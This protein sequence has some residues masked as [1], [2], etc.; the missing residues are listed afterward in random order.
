MEVLAADDEST[1]HLGGHNGASED[2]TADRDKS[3]EGTFLVCKLELSSASVFHY[4]TS[5]HFFHQLFLELFLAS[6]SIAPRH[7][8]PM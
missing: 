2:T 8:I 3:S 7:H 1:M 5:T 6:A 4:I